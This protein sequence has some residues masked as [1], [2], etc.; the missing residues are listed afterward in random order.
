MAKDGFALAFSSLIAYYGYTKF[1]TNL[2]YR[3]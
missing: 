1:G 2:I 3:F